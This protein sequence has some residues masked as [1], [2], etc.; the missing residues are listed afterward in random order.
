MP[1]FYAI[2]EGLCSVNGSDVIAT[3]GSFRAFQD[4]DFITIAGTVC[5]VSGTPADSTHL[6]IQETIPVALTDVAW[7]GNGTVPIFVDYA[8]PDGNIGVRYPGYF[9]RTNLSP[10]PAA[11]WVSGQWPKGVVVGMFGAVSGIPEESGEFLFTVNTIPDGLGEISE[12]SVIRILPDY[13]GPGLYLSIEPL[14]PAGMVDQPFSAKLTGHNGTGPYTY[15][16]VVLPPGVSLDSATGVLSG[17]P[18]EGFDQTVTFTVTDSLGATATL[19]RTIVVYRDGSDDSGDGGGNGDGST[20]TGGNSAPDPVRRA[21]V[22]CEMVIVSRQ[23]LPYA[24]IATFYAN[25]TRIGFVTLPANTEANTVVWNDQFIGGEVALAVGN[26]LT[27]SFSTS[28]GTAL[29]ANVCAVKLRWNVS[30]TATRA[31]RTIG[32]TNLSRPETGGAL[33][34]L[35]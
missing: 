29:P 12:N 28:D 11:I 14:V 24:V 23:K 15:S 25:G 8:P 10:S 19:Q 31:S 3:S 22:A 26:V 33:P 16:V 2:T 5:H 1:Y 32:A 6:T 34:A 7:S 27:C 21:G 4:G 20:E 17:T 18:T 30:R 35:V 13:S 9:F